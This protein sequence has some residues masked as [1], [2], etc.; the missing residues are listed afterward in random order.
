MAGVSGNGM[1]LYGV[2]L[3]DRINTADLNTL[4]AYRVVAQDL[5]KTGTGD[6]GS[7]HAALGDLDKAI[8]A[9]S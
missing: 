3:R 6:D 8:A 7:L 9:K 5:L 4:K 2:I 1:L